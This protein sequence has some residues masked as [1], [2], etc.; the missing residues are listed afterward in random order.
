MS[1]RV[2]D[3]I[4]QAQES[5]DEAERAGVLGPIKGRTFGELLA[6][7]VGATGNEQTD[8]L[9]GRLRMDLGS[10]AS[11][12][13]S[14]HSRGGAGAGQAKAIE[15]KLNSSYMDHALITGGLKSI[16]G[17]TDRY[18]KKPGES[19]TPSTGAADLI[20]DP[21]SGTFKKP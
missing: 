19:S 7:K 15:D 13:A 16:K 9:I 21:A 14:I 8:E 11:G 10:V 2:S 18:A 17:W 3:G 4:E 20:F 12:F 1:A 5:L 6:G